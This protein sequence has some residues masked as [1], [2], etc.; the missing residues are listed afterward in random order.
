MKAIM[1]DLVGKVLGKEIT[2][3]M[4]QKCKHIIPLEKITIRKVKSIKRPRVDMNKLSAIQSDVPT[5]GIQI[6]SFL[7]VICVNC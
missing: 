4:A 5:A 1:K 6:L 7:P 3:E 2:L